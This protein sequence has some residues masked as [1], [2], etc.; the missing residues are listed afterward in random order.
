MGEKKSAS[1][2]TVETDKTAKTKTNGM[3]QYYYG[4]GDSEF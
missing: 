1:V 4:P 3:G 2:N